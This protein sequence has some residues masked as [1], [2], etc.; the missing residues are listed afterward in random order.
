MTR[1]EVQ[2]ELEA[3]A[4]AHGAGLPLSPRQ[5]LILCLVLWRFGD[6]VPVTRL[7]DELRRWIKRHGPPTHHAVQAWIDENRA[8]L[9]FGLNHGDRRHRAR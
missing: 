5:R 8:Q 1:E 2:H 3:A 6:S 9:A 4:A 7:R